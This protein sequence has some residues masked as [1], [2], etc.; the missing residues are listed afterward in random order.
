MSTNAMDRAL[1][2]ISDAAGS[3]EIATLAVQLIQAEALA[4][5]ARALQAIRATIAAAHSE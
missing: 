1:Q 3:P 5:I 2:T 4:E